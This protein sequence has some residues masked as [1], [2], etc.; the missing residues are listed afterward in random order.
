MR[1]AWQLPLVL[2]ILFPTIGSAFTHSDYN[3]STVPFDS[4]TMECFPGRTLPAEDPILTDCEDAIDQLPRLWF[5]GAF[6]NGKPD[7]PFQLPVIRT[8]NTCTVS[9]EMLHKGTSR[10]SS[11]WPVISGSTK[12]MA[13]HCLSSEGSFHLGT[14][15]FVRSGKHSRIISTVRSSTLLDSANILGAISIDK[16]NAAL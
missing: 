7:D 9:V 15:G 11:W 3:I 6:H 1:Q 12:T 10:E 14:G 16:R 13:R 2:A 8:V 4:S 5:R